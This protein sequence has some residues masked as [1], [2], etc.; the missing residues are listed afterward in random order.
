MSAVPA[1]TNALTNR[2]SGDIGA[3]GINASSYF[4]T[5][6]A[7]ILKPRP[8]TLFDE[9]VAVAN[10]A[11]FDFHPNLSGARFRNRNEH[12]RIEGL[13]NTKRRSVRDVVKTGA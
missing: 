1:D 12:S 3:D 11:R 6:H 13:G 5:G 2:P 7:R 9:R 4:M 10:A 8:E